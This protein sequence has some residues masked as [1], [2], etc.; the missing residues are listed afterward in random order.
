ML[1]DKWYL[2]DESSVLVPRLK[3]SAYV[4]WAVGCMYSDLDRP[5]SVDRRSRSDA[6]YVEERG[7][8]VV[9]P[10]VDVVWMYGR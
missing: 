9:R 3:G 8:N 7:V 1:T 4:K 5:D 2:G 10:P 6:G